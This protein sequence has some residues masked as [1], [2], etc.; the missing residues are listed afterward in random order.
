MRK[1]FGTCSPQSAVGAGYNVDYAIDGVAAI[2]ALQTK[3]YHVVLCDVKMPKV[4]GVEVLKFI[5]TNVPGVEVI[6]LT[7]M[8][9]V[10]TAVECM[11]IGAYDYITKPT[12]TDELLTTIQRALERR[13]LL[14]DNLVMKGH[15]RAA[16]RGASRWWAKARAFRKVLDMAAKVA[17]TE[18]TVLIQGSSGTGKELIA[19]FIVPEQRAA[20]SSRSSR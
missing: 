3:L 2:N 15:H 14:I 8:A 9:D 17:P 6:M 11:K 1:H 13:Q 12:T 5:R 16:S 18:S 20:R 19:N 4:D 10:K 7:G